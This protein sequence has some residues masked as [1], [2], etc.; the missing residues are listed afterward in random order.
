MKLCQI[1]DRVDGY[2]LDRLDEA[3]REEFENHYFNCPA[4]FKKVSERA[5]MLAVIKEQ[6]NSIFKEQLNT[7]PAKSG[8]VART[9]ALL[10]TRQWAAAAV[11]AALIVVAVIGIH[12]KS[13]NTSSME[14]FVNDDVV[15]GASVTLI[16][17]V[18]DISDVT[19]EFKWE[20]SGEGVEYRIYIYNHLQEQD[21]FWS[22]DTTET[23]IILPEEAA[24]K[25]KTGEKYSW[26]VKAFSAE[27]S[28]V[29]VSNRIEFQISP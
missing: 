8:L 14:F 27:G 11:S 25:M 1:E 16:S 13:S 22:G 24:A 3:E 15:R 26:Q 23:S 5:A 2:L 19:R 17:P 6:G 7:Q 21:L 29:A 10:S 4:C 12:P 9:L 18:I 20:S 28:L